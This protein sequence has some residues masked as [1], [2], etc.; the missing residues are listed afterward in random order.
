MVSEKAVAE[1][2]SCRDYLKSEGAERLC[3][4]LIREVTTL[5]LLLSPLC[6]QARS[7]DFCWD[8]LIVSANQG[9]NGPASNLYQPNIHGTVSVVTYYYSTSRVLEIPWLPSCYHSQ[10]GL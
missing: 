9:Q 8:T 5:C 2:V 7:F 3:L 6:K 10:V 4:F 1:I